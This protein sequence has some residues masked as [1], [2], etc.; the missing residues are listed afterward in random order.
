MCSYKCMRGCLVKHPQDFQEHTTPPNHAQ[1]FLIT[2]T[3]S[4]IQTAT[5]CVHRYLFQM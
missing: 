1:A 4:E 5:K 2:P 3:L